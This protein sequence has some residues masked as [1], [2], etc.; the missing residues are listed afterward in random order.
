ML[1]G[2]FIF[3]TFLR[4]AIIVL[5]CISFVLHISLFPSHLRSVGSAALGSFV[6]QVTLHVGHSL[7]GAPNTHGA[8]LGASDSGISVDV[9]GASVSALHLLVDI[10]SSLVSC[11]GALAR[12]G[13][14]ARPGCGGNS[15]GADTGRARP[16]HTHVGIVVSNVISSPY[17]TP[18]VRDSDKALR[19]T[20]PAIANF[21]IIPIS[22]AVLETFSFRY[23]NIARAHINSGSSY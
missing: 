18:K 16:Y 2:A 23:W 5:R 19:K 15:Q 11:R 21:L 13:P 20:R 9:S 22:A 17:I 3:F 6:D 14:S 4:A 1:E 10:S 12:L 7:G 8:I